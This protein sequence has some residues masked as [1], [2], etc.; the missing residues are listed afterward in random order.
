[1]N[2][3]AFF[4]PQRITRIALLAAISAV[5]FLPTFTIPIIGFYKLDLSNLPVLLGG[6]SMGPLAGLIIL[7]IKSLTGLITT[8]SGGVGEL[9]D[10]L[11]GS[12]LMLPAVLIYRMNKNRKSALIGMTVGTASLTVCGVLANAWLLIP[13]YVTVMHFPLDAIVK[14]FTDIIPFVDSLEKMLIFI[15]APFNIL[16]GVVLSAVTF[17]LYRH[18]SPIL[19]GRSARG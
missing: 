8:T 19:H 14:T 9:A 15:T 7:G 18:L 4:T 10:F 16:K 5:L 6:F 1:M 2:P 11:L 17:L 12:A 13:F 3:K